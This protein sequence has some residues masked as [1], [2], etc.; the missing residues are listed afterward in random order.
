MMLWFRFS[1]TL[2]KLDNGIKNMTKND[3]DH[4]YKSSPIESNAIANNS[5]VHS[6]GLSRSATRLLENIGE[7]RAMF[8]LLT[9]IKAKIRHG[10]T[11]V[12]RYFL[13]LY[14]VESALSTWPIIIFLQFF[15]ASFF[16]SSSNVISKLLKYYHVNKN[17]KPLIAMLQLCVTVGANKLQNSLPLHI[18]WLLN[19]RWPRVHSG[20]K[21]TMRL[22]PNVWSAS[23]LQC[24]S[25]LTLFSRH[26]IEIIIEH[27]FINSTFSL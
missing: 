18:R 23:K 14:T 3:T 1:W 19:L 21:F 13:H 2:G 22:M 9:T 16:S 10:I 11:F 8:T 6:N 5:N 26:D 4:W 24:W 27:F 20:N 17:K 25:Q 15:Y 7:I 12:W